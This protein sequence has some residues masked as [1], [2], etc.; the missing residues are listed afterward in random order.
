MSE[1][2]K[3]E[4]TYGKPLPRA[5]CPG[6][7][8]CHLSPYQTTRVALTDVAS[9]RRTGQH[10]LLRAL[11]PHSLFYFKLGSLWNSCPQPKA[12]CL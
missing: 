4:G 12:A 2:S 8:N 1:K 3:E 5:I 6:M 11:H 9:F 10:G 7:V